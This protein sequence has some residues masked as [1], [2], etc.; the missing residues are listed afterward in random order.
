MNLKKLS[1]R[2]LKD[3]I[4][5]SSDTLLISKAEDELVARLPDLPDN[6]FYNE[7]DEA[8]IREIQKVWRPS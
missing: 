2:E 1:D 4:N 6:D 7:D 5:N 3:I 8:I